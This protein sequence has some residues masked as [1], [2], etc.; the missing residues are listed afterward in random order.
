MF[1]SSSNKE[2]STN[3]CFVKA[4]IVSKEIQNEIFFSKATLSRLFVQDHFC[5]FLGRC[6]MLGFETNYKVLQ[7]FCRGTHRP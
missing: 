6:E 3:I 1:K 7:H 4:N 2:F 5:Q